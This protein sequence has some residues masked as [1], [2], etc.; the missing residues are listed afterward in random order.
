[1]GGVGSGALARYDLRPISPPAGGLDGGR[2][3]ARVLRPYGTHVP[4]RTLPRGLPQARGH[5]FPPQAWPPQPPQPQHAGGIGRARGGKRWQSA[6][7]SGGGTGGGTGGGNGDND[8][9]ITGGGGGGGGVTARRRGT[10]R[11]DGGGGANEVGISGRRGACGGVGGRGA[12]GGGH[13]DGRSD[14]RSDASDHGDGI[15]YRAFVR[16]G[17]ACGACGAGGGGADGGSAGGAGGGGAGNAC[18]GAGNACGAGRGIG[19]AGGGAGGAGGACGEASATRGRETQPTRP[20]ASAARDFAAAPGGGHGSQHTRQPSGAGGV[21]GAL[22]AVQTRRDAGGGHSACTSGRKDGGSAGGGGGDGY[23]GTGGGGS[24]GGTNRGGGAGGGGGTASSA[25]G[26]CGTARKFARPSFCRGTAVGRAGK[27][28]RPSNCSP[29]DPPLTVSV[30]LY[31][32]LYESV[33]VCAFECVAT[34]EGAG[35]ALPEVRSNTLRALGLGALQGALRTCLSG[36]SRVTAVSTRCTDATRRRLL[37][38]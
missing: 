27:R 5:H 14:S 33:R 2:G 28:E 12:C 16:G 4:L 24:G 6:R 21:V 9:G 3:D 38:V 17:G 34:R 22:G 37:T 11:R 32:V 31:T 29:S 1:M 19:G 36:R 20:R 26:G 15:E 35:G 10:D 13:S 8:G 25:R 18:G 23:G 7:A 30:P